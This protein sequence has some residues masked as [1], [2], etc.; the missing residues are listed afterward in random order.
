MVVAAMPAH[1]DEARCLRRQR[2]RD[3]PTHPTDHYRRMLDKRQQLGRQQFAMQER[4][5]GRWG[6]AL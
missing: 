6:R 4:L 2:N 1:D 3:V 5:V